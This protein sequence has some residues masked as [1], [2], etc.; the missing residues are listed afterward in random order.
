MLKVDILSTIIQFPGHIF[1]KIIIYSAC[2]AKIR[3]GEDKFIF[4]LFEKL[5]TFLKN[6]LWAFNIIH[7]VYTRYVPSLSN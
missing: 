4:D 5:K 7:M 6:P 3:C 2:V 1:A